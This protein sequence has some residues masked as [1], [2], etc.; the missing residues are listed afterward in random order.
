MTG[1]SPELLTT[2]FL[3]AIGLLLLIQITNKKDDQ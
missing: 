1:A 2:L 3:I